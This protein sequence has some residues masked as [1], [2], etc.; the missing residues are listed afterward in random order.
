MN[1]SLKYQT[2]SICP[3]EFSDKQKDGH[4][5]KFFVASLSPSISPSEGRS[6]GRVIGVS[7]RKP[8]QDVAVRLVFL[9]VHRVVALSK[10][11]RVI[12][13]IFYVD[14]DKD[15]GRQNWAALVHCLDLQH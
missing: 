5:R 8:E 3:N 12:I 4:D 7:D 10:D 15:A 1:S 9:H 11:W 6:V 2:Y 13:S 14:V